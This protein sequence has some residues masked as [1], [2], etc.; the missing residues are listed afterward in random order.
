MSNPSSMWYQYEVSMLI[1]LDTT[2]QSY[3]LK[4]V[5]G[6]PAKLLSYSYFSTFQ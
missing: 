1:S 4:A 6:V 2:E 5:T 3:L